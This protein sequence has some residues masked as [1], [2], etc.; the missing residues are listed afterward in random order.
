MEF[1]HHNYLLKNGGVA[2]AADHCMIAMY[3][4]KSYPQNTE[5]VYDHVAV[6]INHVKIHCDTLAAV[7]S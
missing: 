1:Q 4:I 2:E 3:D 5:Q 7:A 6:E